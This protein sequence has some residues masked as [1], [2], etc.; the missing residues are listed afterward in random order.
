LI[1]LMVSPVKGVL[2]VTFIFNSINYHDTIIT[3]LHETRVNPA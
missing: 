1:G 2:S 3:R